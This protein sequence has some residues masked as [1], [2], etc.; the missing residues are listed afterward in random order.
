MFFIDV[1]VSKPGVKPTGIQ[2]FRFRLD[3]HRCHKLRFLIVVSCCSYY[4]VLLRFCV[5]SFLRPKRF[6]FVRIVVVIAS[7]GCCSRNRSVRGV[8]RVAVQHMFS[9][10][11]DLLKCHMCFT[12]SGR[13]VPGDTGFNVVWRT[14]SGGDV[15][16][17]G[18]RLFSVGAFEPHVRGC[19]R[20]SPSASATLDQHC[21]SSLCLLSTC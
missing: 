7:G 9:P 19:A 5:L 4:T 18:C 1:A 6:G 2:L 13:I 21:H 8:W 11:S 10:I 17:L 20:V 14:H 12:Y 3:S 16:T 15:A